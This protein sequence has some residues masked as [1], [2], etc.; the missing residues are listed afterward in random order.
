MPIKRQKPACALDSGLSPHSWLS[1]FRAFALTVSPLT[2][3]GLL[4]D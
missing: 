3:V 2:N 4:S 1:R